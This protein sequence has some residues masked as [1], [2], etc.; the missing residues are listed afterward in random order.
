MMSENTVF[1]GVYVEELPSGV[2]SIS[3]ASTSDTAF[4]DYFRRG[5]LNRAVRISGFAEFERIYGGLDHRSAASYGIQQY[6]LNG[7]QTAWIVRVLAGHYQTSTLKL[8][9]STRAFTLQVAASN[10]GVAPRHFIKAAPAGTRLL[11][12]AIIRRRFWRRASAVIKCSR[13]LPHL[14]RR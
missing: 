7:G 14:C 12:P 11:V 13:R 4:V 3:G 9:D 5:P 8:R 2:R 10:P 1:P 6:F